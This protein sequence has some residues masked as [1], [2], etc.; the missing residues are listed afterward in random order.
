MTTTNS[1]NAGISGPW[2]VDR[3]TTFG[4]TSMSTM[5]KVQLS[6]E[7]GHTELMMSPAETA[8][9]IQENSVGAWIFAD[10][11]MVN[12]D[13]LDEANLSSVSSVR[14]VPSLVGGC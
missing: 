6:D 1:H 2:L 5:I 8:E 11:A 12:A 14:I 10:N 7:N 9:V 13:Q 3:V 4:G